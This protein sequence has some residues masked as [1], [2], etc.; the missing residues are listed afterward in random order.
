[1]KMKLK[2]DEIRN[3]S[4][5]EREKQLSDLREEIFKLQS[6][7][8]MGTT[9]PD[10]MRIRMMKRSIEK[11]APTRNEKI[12]RFSIHF[13]SKIPKVLWNRRT[14]G[15][16]SV[17]KLA[18]LA[19]QHFK[20]QVTTISKSHFDKTFDISEENALRNAQFFSL[21]VALKKIP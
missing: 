18:L 6:S 9:L 15:V 11:S 5:I 17:R 4:A 12:S 1:M 3:M 14:F 19:F 8:A 2:I 7:N 21:R 20:R 10:P 13:F 16:W